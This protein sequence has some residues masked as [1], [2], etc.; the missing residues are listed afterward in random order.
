M[1]GRTVPLPASPGQ[2]YSG[3]QVRGAEGRLLRDGGGYPYT[4]RA[5]TLQATAPIGEAS[6]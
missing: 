4:P 1:I 2:A 6:L 5:R 3:A